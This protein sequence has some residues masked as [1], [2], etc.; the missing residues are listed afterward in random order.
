M[1][2][3]GLY[4]PFHS[5]GLRLVVNSNYPFLHCSAAPVVWFHFAC[6]GKKGHHQNADTHVDFVDVFSGYIRKK[7]GANCSPSYPGLQVVFGDINVYG[8]NP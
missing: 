8:L 3:L 4:M 1:K 5:S 2:A 7:K 6:V